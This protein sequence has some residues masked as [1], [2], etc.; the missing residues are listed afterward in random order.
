MSQSLELNLTSPAFK[1]DPYPAFAWLRTDDPVHQ[2]AS[3]GGQSTWLITRYVD[4]EIALRDQRFIKDRKNLL[5]PKAR[6]AL[7]AS[8]P[9]AADLMT[10]MMTD[11][12]PPDHTRLRSLANLAFTPRRVEQW[13][14]R[15]QQITDELIDAV[16]AKGHMDLIEEFAFPL[17]LKVIL[18]MLGIPMSDGPQVHTWTKAIADALGDPVASAQVSPHLQAFYLYL[19]A[20]IETRRKTLTNDLV[21]SWIRAE[22]EQLST[23]ELV[24]MVFLLIVAGHDTTGSLIGT[25]MLALLTHP[26]QLALLR[27]Q[28][29]LIK[30][31][32]EEFLRYRSPFMHATLRWASEDVLLGDKLIRRGDQVI[33][34]LASANRDDQAFA[35]PNTLDITRQENPHL[36]FGK[37]IHFCLGAQ[38]ARLEGQ[39]AISTLIHCLPH[40]RLQTDP[41]SLVWRP[42]SLALGLDHLPV[43]F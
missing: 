9:S 17:P 16:A 43:L 35:E 30:T 42:G 2:L 28:P 1:A 27:Q 32:I 39:I 40:L 25:S 15:I 19:H 37:G 29:A 41:Q 22:G 20:L 12:D 18:E 24:T 14:P 11:V 33:I 13:R 34:S 3:S 7:P 36:A 8:Q 31:A 38:L 6:K 26:E 23:R 21:S 10:L 5:S 4:A